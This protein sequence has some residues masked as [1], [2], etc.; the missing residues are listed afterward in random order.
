MV[1]DVKWFIKGYSMYWRSK[2][3]T[4]A[5]HGLLNPAPIPAACFD[6]WSM[7]FVRLYSILSITT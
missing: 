4:T 6:V 3:L 1:T 7:D 5:P 2:N